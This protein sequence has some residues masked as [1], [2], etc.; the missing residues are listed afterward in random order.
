MRAIFVAQPGGPEVLEI[1]DVPLPEPGDRQIRVRV[2]AFGLNRAELLQ[3]RGLYPA[4][5]GCPTDIPGLE[6]AGEV[7]AVGPGVEGIE[8]G[9]RVMGIVCGG[10]YA[11]HVIAPAGHV[12][13]IPDGL[14]FEEAAAIPEAFITAYDA[15]ERVRVTAGAW[16]LVHAAGSSVGTAAVQLAKAWKAKCIGTS[17]T[18]SKLER[19][20]RLGLDV[21]VDSVNEDFVHA[22][23]QVTGDGA[24]VVVDLIGGASFPQTLEALAPQGRLILVGVTAGRRADLDLAVIMRR[25]LHIQGTVLRTRSEVEKTHLIQ[26]FAKAVLPLFAESR[27]QPVLDRVFEFGEIRA[28]HEYLESNRS[29]GSVV[30]RAE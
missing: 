14:S 15:L 21:G 17:R 22:V 12:V 24:D 9:D 7:D 30:V 13:P 25:R 6:H 10:S 27:V 3:R 18:P 5:A 29:F 11:E 8:I 23:R 2:G 20:A 1:R 16:V 4:P 26:S 19:V 28:A